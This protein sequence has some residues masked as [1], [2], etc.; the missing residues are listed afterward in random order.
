[1]GGRGSGGAGGG[2]A[3]GGGSGG[4]ASR[5]LQSQLDQAFEERPALRELRITQVLDSAPVGTTVFDGTTTVTD[6]SGAWSRETTYWE[7]TSSYGWT[8]FGDTSGYDP[9]SSN[10]VAKTIAKRQRVSI[11]K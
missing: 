6:R 11:R 1:M 8:R 10:R 4:A 2:G 3:R 9:I 7:K 5:Q